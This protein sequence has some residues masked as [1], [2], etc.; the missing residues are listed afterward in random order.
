MNIYFAASIR[1]WRDDRE[2]YLQMIQHLQQYGKVLTEH[3][4]D[5][6]LNDE[7]MTDHQIW[8]MDM[9]RLDE[10]DIVVAEVTQPSIWVWYELGRAE[11]LWKKIIPLYR[12][13][14]KKKVSAMI[15][16]N[17]NH[18]TYYYQTIHEAKE[19]LNIIFDHD[20]QS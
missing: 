7:N 18:P 5:P 8:E 10:C 17:P 1:W 4:A 13:G 14:W 16:G 6:D 19:I 2:L 3:I 11:Q 9:K 20:P 12:E 15:S